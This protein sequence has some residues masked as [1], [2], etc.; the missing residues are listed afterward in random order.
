MHPMLQII[1]NVC[2]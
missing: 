1:E 2:S